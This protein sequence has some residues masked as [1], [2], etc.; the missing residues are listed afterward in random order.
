[1]LVN[2]NKSK[3]QINDNERK[4]SDNIQSMRSWIRKIEQSTNSVSSRLSAVEKRISNRTNNNSKN[5][6]SGFPI[7][8]GSIDSFID[9]LKDEKEEKNLEYIFRVF[10]SELAMI[11]DDIDTQESEIKKFKEHIDQINN[12][13]SET[14]DGL[15]KT[16]D[17]SEKQI[18]HLN[19]RIGNLER[20]AP[21]TMKIGKMQIP[22][23][24]SGITAGSIALFAALM[25]AL[26][27]T[28]IITS[29]V[30]LVLAGIV[31]FGTTVFKTLKS[32]NISHNS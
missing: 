7:I 16:R 11:M 29:P 18:I 6:L 14:N 5:D 4:S 2:K 10:D 17:I 27:K 25:V 12:S 1:L 30:F 15:M 23:E 8:D 20:N 28:V 19:E 22:I 24:I 32:R 9:K 3:K 26:N 31:F 13:I 21:P